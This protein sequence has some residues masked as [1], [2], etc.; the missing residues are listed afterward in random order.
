[1]LGSALC[2]L[3][4]TW[5]F[6]CL[7]P[8]SVFNI[9]YSRVVFHYHMYHSLFNLFSTDRHGLFLIFCYWKTNKVTVTPFIQTCAIESVRINA[10]KWDCWIKGQRHLYLAEVRWPSIRVYILHTPQQCIRSRHCHQEWGHSGGQDGQE[11]SSSR[12]CPPA[13]TA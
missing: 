11:L 8:D 7:H 10:H 12:M 13:W 9:F 4:C 3:F 5:I 1:M 2:I 6:P